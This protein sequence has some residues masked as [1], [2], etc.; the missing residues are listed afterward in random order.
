MYV[1]PNSK[2]FMP[3]STDISATF[4]CKTDLFT[5]QYQ[6]EMQSFDGRYINIT[7]STSI[8]ALN[9]AIYIYALSS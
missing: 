2:T 1:A 6:E 5:S 4:L 3:S 8:H 7:K 9:S